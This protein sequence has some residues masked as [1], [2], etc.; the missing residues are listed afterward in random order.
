[1]P[2]E[3]KYAYHDLKPDTQDM[4]AEVLAGLRSTPKTLSPKFFYDA[5]GSVLFERITELPEYYLTR[6]EMALFDA[7]LADIAALLPADICV[8]EYGSGSSLKIR[9]LLENLTPL[10]YVPVDISA[11]HLEENAKTLH[12]DFPGI[13]VYPVCADFTAAFTLPAA[14]A[15]LTKLAFFPGS[16]IG[17][18]DPADARQFLSNV[19]H[20]V[21]D[22]GMLLIGVDR[23]KDVAVLEAA[24][25]DSAGVTAAFNLNILTH[26]N[27]TLDGDFQLE[28]FEHVARYNHA[29]GCIQMFLRSRVNQ[30][31][32]IAGEV[33]ELAAGEEIHTENSYKYHRSPGLRSICWPEAFAP[34]QQRSRFTG[35]TDSRRG[36]R[37]KLC[38]A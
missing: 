31:V 2:S 33:I 16:S 21:G 8:V 29:A 23:K 25:D 5:E 32:S 1:M 34:D 20:T 11:E 30:S 13:A 26:L 7:H 27:E 36:S 6:T 17:N 28:A 18:F 9:K 4:A 15:G 38:R 35:Q 10:A 22:D 14:V 24:Y 19:R 37:K 3:A 12:A